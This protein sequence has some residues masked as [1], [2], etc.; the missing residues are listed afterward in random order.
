MKAKI[1]S[2]DEENEVVDWIYNEA[3]TRKE[4]VD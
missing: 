1:S 2:F 3:L 4:E